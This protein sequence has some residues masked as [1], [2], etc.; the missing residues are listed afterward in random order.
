MKKSLFVII[1]CL[2]ILAGCSSRFSYSKSGVSQQQVNKDGY[3]CQK[4]STYRASNAQVNP[5][6][7]TASSGVEVNWNMVK[8]CLRARGYTIKA[9]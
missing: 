1:P 5:Y 2:V 7:G 6:G 8:A 4:E 3:E 9:I